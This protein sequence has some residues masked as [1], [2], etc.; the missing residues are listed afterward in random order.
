MAFHNH[1]PDY[2]ARIVTASCATTAERFFRL[3]QREG[4]GVIID[5]RRSTAYRNVNFAYEEDL[6]Y[7]CRLH[8]IAYHHAL[9]L[10]PPKALRDELHK[11]FDP[12]GTPKDVR[13]EA[14][15]SFLENYA[16]TLDARKAAIWI[17]GEP[18]LRTL[19]FDS[20]ARTVAVICACHHHEDCHRQV[21][22]AWLKREIGMS[23]L[24]IEH[25]YDGDPPEKASPR[26]VLARSVLG[27]APT[28]KRGGDQ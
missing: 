3:M 28:K 19:L 1:V 8:R 2:L 18:S 10:A 14:F 13:E 7:I 6:G 24:K 15:T 5:T 17:E 23:D 9:E 12:P 11:H 27:I 21:T 20:D 4:V 16:K 25:I 22:V 26:R